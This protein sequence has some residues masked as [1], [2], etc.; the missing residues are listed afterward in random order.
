MVSIFS[1]PIK[2]FNS[3][4]IKLS[5]YIGYLLSFGFREEPRLYIAVFLSIF[6]VLLELLAIA[7]LY[8]LMEKVSSNSVGSGLFI[9]FLVSVWRQPSAKELLMMF[10]ALVALRV[11][12]LMASTL[13]ILRL[14]KNILE[15]ICIKNFAKITRDISFEELKSR[16]IGYFITL[17]G[18]D[19]VRASSI[20]VMSVQFFSLL[21]MITLYYIAIL[22]YSGLV[23]AMIPVFLFIAGISLYFMVKVSHRIGTE[24][25]ELSR[26]LNATFFD[27]LGNIKSVRSMLS[28]NFVINAYSKKI[29]QYTK[30][31][32]KVECT[33]VL[34]KL[35]PV[36]FLIF[37]TGLTLS[38]FHSEF[39]DLNSP[40]IVT[41]IVLLMRFLPSIGQLVNFALKII[42]ELKSGTDI[43]KTL[44]M[45]DNVGVGD[46]HSLV[47]KSVHSIVFDKVKFQHQ[48][49]TKSHTYNFTIQKNKTYAIVGPSGSGKTTCID[50]LVKFYQFHLIQIVT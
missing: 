14:G 29:T 22:Q 6:S 36:I 17:A 21:L 13:L 42:S 26:D 33:P 25:T 4:L 10:M 27:V 1:T 45:S 24:E 49:S 47:L 5:Q 43:I 32:Y 15:K 41:I 34:I 18:D 16:G 35:I 11:L 23:A 2:L 20:I 40:F 31:L 8:P 38:F 30:L 44:K 39:A 28:E 37:V 12:F 48:K 3:R 46:A 19:A 9:E 7:C 50:L